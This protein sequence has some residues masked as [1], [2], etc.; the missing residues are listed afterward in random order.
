M[1]LLHDLFGV[2]IYLFFCLDNLQSGSKYLPSVFLLNFSQILDEKIS[3][4]PDDHSVLRL[5]ENAM[6]LRPKLRNHT[7]QHQRRLVIQKT[8]VL[9]GVL[10]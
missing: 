2:F 4:F 10:Q 7:L 9:M 3:P 1:Y 8:S 6:F 5:N